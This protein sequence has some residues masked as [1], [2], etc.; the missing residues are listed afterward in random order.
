MI[1]REN[2]NTHCIVRTFK[3]KF[4][5]SPHRQRLVD[6]G[7][8]PQGHGPQARVPAD[9]GDPG[10]LRHR[11]HH[12]Q[13]PPLLPSPPQRPLQVRGLSVHRPGRVALR[14]DCSH[15]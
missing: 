12:L 9:P 7:S 1:G 2:E 15:G 14:A 13:R 11:L 5:S 4:I 10:Q 3:Y 8:R 6:H